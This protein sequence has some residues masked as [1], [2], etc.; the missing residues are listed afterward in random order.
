MKDVERAEAPHAVLDHA[1]HVGLDGD[2][3]GDRERLAAGLLDARDRLTCRGRV[4]V[5][6]DHP[7]ALLGE[8]HCG[9]TSHAHARARDER[10]LSG[11]PAAHRPPPARSS[12]SAAPKASTTPCMS[13]GV[14]VPMFETRN[15]YFRMSPCPA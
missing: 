14:R 7:R 5:A 8:E 6:H 13:R 3:A 9:L 1:L 2:V 12:A 11:Q 4:D 15:A 10:D